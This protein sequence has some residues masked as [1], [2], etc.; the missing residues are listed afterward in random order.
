M[1]GASYSVWAAA[2]NFFRLCGLNN[3]LFS[4]VLE[5]GSSRSGCQH[6]QV[7]GGDPLL[8]LRVPSTW[9]KIAIYLLCPYSLLFAGEPSGL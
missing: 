7:W 2:G 8:G 1:E 9:F 6:G 4:T 3:N 5:A